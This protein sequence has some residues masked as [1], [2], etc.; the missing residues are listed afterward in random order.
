[1]P[2]M[3]VKSWGSVVVLT[4]TSLSPFLALCPTAD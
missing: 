4:A 3:D 2:Q 1:L